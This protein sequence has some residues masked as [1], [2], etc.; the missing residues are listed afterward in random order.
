MR[1]EVPENEI[2]VIKQQIETEGFHKIEQDLDSVSL[3]LREMLEN[4][5]EDSVAEVLSAINKDEEVLSKTRVSEDKLVQALSILFQLMNLVEENSAAQYRRKVENRLGASFIRGSWAETFTKWQ[6]QGLSED[7]IAA[8]LPHVLVNP[9]LTAHPTEAKRISILELHRELYLLLVKKEN[10]IWS[11]TEKKVI[12]ET[13]HALLERWWRSGEVYLEK[14]DV[15]SE[16]SSVLHYFTRVFPEALKLSDERLKYTWRAFGFDQ[17]KLQEPEQFPTILLGSWVGG[18]RDGHPYVTADVT[19]ET[20]ME[21]RMAALDLIEGQLVE[22]TT[23]MSFS[24]NRN[25]VPQNLLD[26]IDGMKDALGKAGQKA[27][28]RNPH[29]PWRQFLNLCLVK[30]V[31]TRKERD[32]GSEALYVSAAELQ[33]DLR[34]LRESLLELGADLIVDT[35]LF[36]VERQVKAFGFHLAR[37]DIRQNSAF[38]DKAVEQMLA[39]AS[40]NDTDFA[41]WDEE[42]RIAFLTEELKSNRPFVVSG[43]S[44]GPEA[45]QVLDCFRTVKN[46]IE[47]YGSDGIGSLIV[48]MTRGVSDLLTVYLFMREVG[49]LDSGLQ[50]VPLFETIE[51]L[52]Q[53]PAILDRYLAH[54]AVRL[55]E[56]PTGLFQEVMLGYSDSNKDG[57]IVASRWNIYKA[58]RVLTEV[59]NKHGVKLRFFHGI[60]GTISRGGGKYHRF[61]DSMP[62]GSFSGEI[63]L[64]VQGETIAQQFANL[65]NAN[66]NLEMLLSGSALQTGYYLYPPEQK[67]YPFEALDMLTK[68]SL[69]YYQKMIKHP[70]FIK[71][72]SESTPIDVL[73]QSKIG[74]RPARRTGRRSLADLR[75]IPWVFSWNQSRYNLTAWYGVGYGLKTMQ[76]EHPDLYRQLQE[77]AHKW[78][79]LRYTLIHI[80]TGLLNADTGLMTSYAALVQNEQVRHEFLDRILNEHKESIQQVAS[81]LGD[82][83]QSRRVSLL[84]NI[85]RR[86]RPLFSLHHLQVNKLREWRMVKEEERQTEKGNALLQKLLVITTAISGGVKNTG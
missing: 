78:P 81:L 80:E 55:L 27:V 4:L 38:H 14:P 79:F 67:P 77:N 65:V 20:L 82:Q 63:K 30:L 24:D 31:N 60:G 49:L 26:R 41:N 66:Y 58:E 21:H 62:M 85:N 2:A 15:S 32:R 10:V 74:S 75:A 86:K 35:F 47:K 53:S 28:D 5:H 37:L 84:E 1:K 68:L 43:A 25:E 6:K 57:G 42:K 13:I 3:F 33:D 17:K 52:D 48:S 7:Q 16:R 29:E 51:D 11:E 50:V 18:D 72:Y 83:T 76:K 69:D 36:P 23:K 34:F 70:D 9:V 39:F 12:D 59:A 45:N 54:P 71:F 56:L 40:S 46:H 64:T 19:R 73:E 22:L 44:V 8:I 61:L